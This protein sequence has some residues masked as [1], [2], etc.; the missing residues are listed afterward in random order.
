VEDGERECE[1][2]GAEE[3]GRGEA[4]EIGQAVKGLEYV[5]VYLVYSLSP[6]LTSSLRPG[7][8]LPALSRTAPPRQRLRPRAATP[9]GPPSRSRS[10]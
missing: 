2:L 9:S 8:I 7:P 1:E 10:L 5:C 4:D 3:R 6:S